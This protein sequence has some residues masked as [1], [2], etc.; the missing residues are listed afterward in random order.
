MKIAPIDSELMDKDY[1]EIVPDEDDAMLIEGEINMLVGDS[2]SED[3]IEYL[4]ELLP[5]HLSLLNGSPPAPFEVKSQVMQIRIN[6]HKSAA[7]QVH[8][9]G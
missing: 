3:E 4:R 5:A 2:V 9:S 6:K 1:G 8:K 7:F